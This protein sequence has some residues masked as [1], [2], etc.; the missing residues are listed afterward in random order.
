LLLAGNRLEEAG[1]AL[2]E[3]RRIRPQL[4]MRE[5]RGVVGGR[6]ADAL[7]QIWEL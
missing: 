1:S 3:A 2:A 7:Q 6:Y 4:S 5:V